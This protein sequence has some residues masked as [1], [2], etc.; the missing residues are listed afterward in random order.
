MSAAAAARRSDTSRG[1]G[2][3]IYGRGALAATLGAARRV[4]TTTVT[5]GHETGARAGGE[6]TTSG[7][8]ARRVCRLRG[9]VLVPYVVIAGGRGGGTVDSVQAPRTSGA[10]LGRARYA[11]GTAQMAPRWPLDLPPPPASCATSRGIK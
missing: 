2:V 1:C 10:H 6:Q 11:F 8:W 5:D 7:G 3:R 9:G 4:G